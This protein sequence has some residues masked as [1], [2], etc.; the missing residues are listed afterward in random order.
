M[1]ANSVD[2]VTVDVHVTR[3]FHLLMWLARAAVA[4]AAY[5]AAFTIW[6]APKL[7]RLKVKR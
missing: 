6:C 7:V 4:A 5:F 1:P 2:T 3:A